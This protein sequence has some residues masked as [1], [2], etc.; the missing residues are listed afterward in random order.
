MFYKACK[1]SLFP[2]VPMRSTE[3]ICI[4][5]ILKSFTK[6]TF[7]MVALL[8]TSLQLLGQTA[9]S[10]DDND[11]TN[12]PSWQ[13]KTEQFSV[14]SG[15]LHLNAPAS[16]G[17]AFISTSSSTNFGTWKLTVYLRFNSS[18]SN[19]CRYYL[20]SDNPELDSPLQGYYVQI[21]GASDDVSLFRQNGTTRTKIID[22][23]DGLLDRND[24][25]VFLLVERNPDGLWQLYAGIDP[26]S[27]G[28]QG[29][30]VDK[31]FA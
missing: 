7:V 17:S 22:G 1:A 29:E 27:L 4:F 23:I 12:D 21:G 20:Q 2:V 25:S 11:L 5:S 13:G 18:S 24:V 16:S 9:D 6:K 30:V 31:S 28:K 26:N 3:Q 14:T 15:Q 8:L 10:F 19:Y